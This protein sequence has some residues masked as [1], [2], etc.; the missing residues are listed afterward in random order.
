MFDQDA[1]ERQKQNRIKLMVLAKL[2]LG[3]A[4]G[5]PVSGDRHDEL[6]QIQHIRNIVEKYYD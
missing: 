2:N 6:L 4:K 5:P 3:F 1:F